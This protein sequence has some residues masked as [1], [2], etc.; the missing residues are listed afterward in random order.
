[1]PPSHVP[2]LAPAESRDTASPGRECDSASISRVGQY[3]SIQVENFR[4]DL[5]PSRTNSASGIF[6]LGNSEYD[7]FLTFLVGQSPSPKRHSADMKAP[8]GLASQRVG[9]IVACMIRGQPQY[10]LR[11]SPRSCVTVARNSSSMISS[12][13]MTWALQAL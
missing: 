13:F 10:P 4:V 8:D 3:L 1:M 12:E 2:R 11:T 5:F 6:R 9:W 7:S